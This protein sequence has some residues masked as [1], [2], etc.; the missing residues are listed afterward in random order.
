MQN[1]HG[2]ILWDIVRMKKEKKKD[3][4]SFLVITGFW[5][6]LKLRNDDFYTQFTST[7]SI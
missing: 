5:N 6:V 4:L 1:L 3:I 2:F 7:D